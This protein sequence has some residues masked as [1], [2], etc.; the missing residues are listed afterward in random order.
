MCR[1]RTLHA[2]PARATLSRR[3]PLSRCQEGSS[4]CSQETGRALVS[5]TGDETWETATNVET[6]QETAAASD[7]AVAQESSV[8]ST[9]ATSRPQHTWGHTRTGQQSRTSPWHTDHASPPSHGTP[10]KKSLMLGT[11]QVL[12]GSRNHSTETVL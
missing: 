8:S 6:D 4:R 11:N 7:P 12:V 1:T 2:L 5:G 3:M 10:A 9:V